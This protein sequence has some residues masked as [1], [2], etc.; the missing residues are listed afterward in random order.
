MW[1]DL[2]IC[3]TWF[4]HTCDMTYSQTIVVRF[5]HISGMTHWFIRVTHLLDTYAWRDSCDMTHT[6]VWHDAYTCLTCLTHVGN[7]L[8]GTHDYL[9]RTQTRGDTNDRWLK[10]SLVVNDD[11][12]ITE[13]HSKITHK[14]LW[15]HQWWHKWSLI[16]DTN[17]DSLVT[18]MTTDWLLRITQRDLQVTSCNH[19][20]I[21]SHQ[22]WCI[23]CIYTC[24]YIYIH[25]HIYMNVRIQS[26]MN[27][28]MAQMVT[29]RWHKWYVAQMTSDDPNTPHSKHAWLLPT[30]PANLH[31]TYAYVW[32]DSFIRV[33]WL[34]NRRGMTHSYVWRDSCICVT[35]LIDL[36]EWHD[37][38]TCV[39]WLI[40]THHLGD[41]N[42][43]RHE[44]SAF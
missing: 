28:C 32:R 8:G 16:G 10:W 37:S 35:W 14:W 31:S 23:W 15:N 13:D 17:D 24:T 41:T 1:H 21:M 30:A 12:L 5:V 25:V 26:A 22:L 18:H 7:T 19:S 40:H 39:T 33:T 43:K 44:Y 9:K 29:H 42:D 36:F 38:F 34:I 20:M 6:H 3:V 27:D 4:I 2:L 11:S